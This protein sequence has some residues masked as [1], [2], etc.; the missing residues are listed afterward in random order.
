M[1][2]RNEKNPS[3]MVQYPVFVGETQEGLLIVGNEK[4]E[5]SELCQMFL[6]MRWKNFFTFCTGLYNYGW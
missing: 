4:F 5:M 3:A 6:G 1:K 2:K